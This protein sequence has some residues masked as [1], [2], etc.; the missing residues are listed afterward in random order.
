MV[1]RAK[2]QF[3]VV[4]YDIANNRRRTKIVKLL[5]KH[6]SRVNLSV[7]ECMLTDTQ[8]AKLRDDIWRVTKH[9]EDTV[10]Y[11]PLCVD[12]YAKIVYQPALRRTFDKITIV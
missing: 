11:Y 8:Y 6:G 12:C 3:I 5:E 9:K 1:T 4:A 2:K 7:F 10:I